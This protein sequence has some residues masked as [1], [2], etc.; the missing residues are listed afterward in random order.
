MIRYKT[1]AIFLLTCSCYSEADI[2][3]GSSS[4][5]SA[6]DPSSTSSSTSG[7]SSTTLHSEETSTSEASSSGESTARLDASSDSD[8]DSSGEPPI[9]DFALYFDGVASMQSTEAVD[10]E[11]NGSFTIETWV[12]FDSPDSVGQ[13]V[14]HRG[15]GTTGWEL[16]ITEGNTKIGFGVFDNN[17]EWH[18]A[19]GDDVAVYGVGW[20][21]V[22]GSKDGTSLL[23]H[24]D[25]A[26]VATQGC[27]VGMGAPTVPLRIGLGEVPLQIAA[28]DDVRISSPARYDSGF[29]PSVEFEID[30]DTLILVELDEGVGQAANE[31]SMGLLFD[32]TDTEWIPGNTE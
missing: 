30:A 27:P 32:L 11:L 15:V 25:G 26:L 20:H 16:F 12:R 22:A 5:S 6:T 13:I 10:L 4:S 18:E 2:T 7:S 17:G 24:V 8:S 9:E 19:I 28:V 14:T 23:V 1:F 29:D 3:G 31:L 21:H